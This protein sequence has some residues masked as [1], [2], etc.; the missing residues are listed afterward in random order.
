MQEKPLRA[1]TVGEKDLH[2][3]I[4]EVKKQFK[5]IEKKKRE[6]ENR[7]RAA[8]GDEPGIGGIA[9]WKQSKNKRVFDKNSFRDE[10]P[11]LYEKYIIEQ[12]G[13]RILRIKEEQYDDRT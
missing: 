6:L 1:A 13:S 4:I 8:I 7:L 10:E 9:T 5:E 2:E 12:P 11:D 3:K